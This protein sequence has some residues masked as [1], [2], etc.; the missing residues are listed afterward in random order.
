M[1]LGGEI[2]KNQLSET[3]ISM[4]HNENFI[5]MTKTIG[6]SVSYYIHGKPLQKT[7]TFNIVYIYEYTSTVLL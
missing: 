5:I 3:T 4:A 1:L 6:M 7:S 2:E